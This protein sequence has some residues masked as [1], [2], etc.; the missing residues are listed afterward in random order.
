[1][2]IAA[3]RRAVLAAALGVAAA[4]TSLAPALS[5]VCNPEVSDCTAQAAPLVIPDTTAE[6]WTAI[7]AKLADI[8][9][10]IDKR[11]AR[12][13]E[14]AVRPTKDVKKLVLALPTR[15]KLAKGDD[16][17][18][19]NEINAAAAQADKLV[20]AITNVAL[21]KTPPGGRELAALTKLEE[22]L[23]PVRAHYP[24]GIYAPPKS[25]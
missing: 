2:T 24:N 8:H 6:I 16:V 18:V 21:G 12:L 20:Q 14:D 19:L 23:K 1:M 9:T 3:F 5:A 4:A 13:V 7:D 17:T 25:P 11:L 10:V 22:L 15:T